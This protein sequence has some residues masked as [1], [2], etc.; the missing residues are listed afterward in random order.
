MSIDQHHGEALHKIQELQE[1]KI[2]AIDEKLNKIIAQQQETKEAKSLL[3]YISSQVS[4]TNEKVV[5]NDA[6][7]QKIA[8][9]E[10]QLKKIEKN[11]TAITEYLDEDDTEYFDNND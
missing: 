6:L 7:M 11:V 8:A 2:D 3:E 1:S 4:L 5:E 10:K 9:M